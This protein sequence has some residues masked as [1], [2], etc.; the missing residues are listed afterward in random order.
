MFDLPPNEVW[1]QVKIQIFLYNYL[2]VG[3]KMS[4][5]KS[6]M[7]K[8][9]E[10][11]PQQCKTALELPKG[12]SVSG[13]VDK[14]VVIGMG[15]SAVGGDLLKAYMHNSKVPVFV[16]RDYKVPNFVDENS[17]VF[18]VSYSGNTEETISAYESALK[19]KAKSVAV[20][21][22][23]SLGQMAKKVIKIP[24]GLQPRAALG[25]LFFPV[26]GVLA[27]SEIVDVKNSEIT[28][29]LDILSKT[30]EF[31]AIGEGIA[32]KIGQR[33]PLIYA[34][35]MLNAVAYRWK[36]QFNENSKT[37][38]FHHA[39]SEMNHNEIVG[40][41]TMDKG[42]YVA[43]FIRDKEDNERIKKRM[44][45]TKEIIST[46]IDVEEVFTKG[47]GLLSR[48]FSGIYYGDFASYYIALAKKIDPTPVAVIENLKK[49]LK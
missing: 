17:L 19:K 45:I 16:V 10:G 23:G 30:E 48:I 7:L 41:Q 5:D 44:D 15:G 26:L 24:G 42:D 18:A 20:T 32:K 40:Y 31:K 14:I 2:L 49:R 3:Y 11:F 47:D 43:I 8:V 12:M 22:G 37:A 6:N 13:K 36:T 21:S 39:F 38:A 34:S 29:M 46:R 1:W 28:E 25:Y 33:T 35:E 4:M 9:I 27:N